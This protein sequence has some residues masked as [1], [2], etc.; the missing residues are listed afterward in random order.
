MNEQVRRPL[1]DSLMKAIR[2]VTENE[3]ASTQ[4]RFEA[5]VLIATGYGLFQHAES[6]NPTGY[7]IPEEQWRE[8]SGWLINMSPGV[9][10]AL[11]WMNLGPSAYDPASESEGASQ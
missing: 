6:V 2:A 3:E 9:N 5:V 4:E 7:A 8:V 1:P 11:D 10:A